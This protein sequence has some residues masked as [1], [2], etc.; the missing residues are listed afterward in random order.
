MVEGLLLSSERQLK[1]FYVPNERK[2]RAISY[3][4]DIARLLYDALAVASI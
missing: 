4:C 1:E 2:K 3:I